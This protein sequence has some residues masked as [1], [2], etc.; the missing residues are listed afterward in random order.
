MK[1]ILTIILALL[2]LTGCIQGSKTPTN[3]TTETTQIVSAGKGE[4]SII[5]PYSSSP[6]RQGY[7]T[8]MR[9]IDTIEIGSRLQELSKEYFSP[10]TYY[11]AEGSIITQEHYQHLINR[12]SDDYPYSLNSPSDGSEPY[13]EKVKDEKGI[14]TKTVTIPNP[15]FVHS[16]YEMN[17]YKNKD[18]AELNGISLGVVLDR[19]QIVNRETGLTQAITDESLFQIANDIISPRLESYMRKIPGMETMPMM[20]GFYVQDSVDDT[21]NGRY[22]PGHFIGHA[23]Y[24]NAKTIPTLTA[25]NERWMYMGST[26]ATQQ[27]PQSSSNFQIFKR[28][29]QDFIADESVGVVGQAFVVD[30]EVKKYVIEI[31]MGAKTQLEFHGLTQY[32]ST[33]ISS[34][35]SNQVPVVVNIKLFQN[36]RAVINYQPGSNPVITVI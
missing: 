16:I 2:V 24:D 3:E 15:M 25:N 32:V 11:I 13:V 34:I 22:L 4:Y 10:S 30:N 27:L 19:N 18:K 35:E 31:T 7:A 29:V 20:I 17:F 23:Y 28:R 5:T 14:V 1:K 12:R 6:L 21:L 8:A 36:T 9:E 33:L 26:L